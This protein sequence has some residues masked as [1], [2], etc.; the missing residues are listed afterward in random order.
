MLWLCAKFEDISTVLVVAF[1][2][3]L[4]AAAFHQWVYPLPYGI[5]DAVRFE[6]RAWEWAQAGLVDAVAQFDPTGPWV[7]S[8]V[9]AVV[10][11]VTDRSELLLQVLNVIGGTL[12]VVNVYLIA[13]SLWG[14]HRAYRV[15]WLTALFPFLIQISAVTHREVLIVFLLTLGIYGSIRWMES[16]RLRQLLLAASALVGSALVH[17]GLVVAVAAAVLVFVVYASAVVVRRLRAGRVRVGA[18]V[19]V[20]GL[21]GVASIVA[22]AGV[23]ELSKVGD[24]VEV[25]VETLG[26]L[27][28]ARARGEAEYLSG[29]YPSSISDVLVQLPIRMIYFL[30]SPLPWDVSSTMH[31]AALI[32]SGLYALI[33]L[34]LWKSRQHIL[35]DRRATFILFVTLSAIAVFALVTSNFGTAIRH[36]AKFAPMLMALWAA[37]ITDLRIVLFSNR[38]STRSGAV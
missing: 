11:S 37:P 9:G 12:I 20:I 4:M 22:M 35:G 24:V 16:G 33:L 21:I 6:Q 13:R 32:D 38:G 34:G 17:G 8:W 7:Y 19:A 18:A 25:D 28:E 14:R 31:A 10:Y 3:R 26:Q 1:G 23:P 30:L 29:M 15:A 5:S 2:V 27:A 36:R